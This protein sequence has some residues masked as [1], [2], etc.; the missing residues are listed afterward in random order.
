M[1]C[2]KCASF[3][4]FFPQLLLVSTSLDSTSEE[5]KTESGSA[6]HITSKIVNMLQH[7]DLTRGAGKK[8]KIAFLKKNLIHFCQCIGHSINTREPVN[9][10]QNPAEKLHLSAHM[11]YSVSK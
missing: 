6:L 4:F 3:S 2:Q 8:K 1:A 5:E 11:R 10:P 7:L 9:L